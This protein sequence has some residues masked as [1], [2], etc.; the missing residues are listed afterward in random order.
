M[1][2]GSEGGELVSING[3]VLE[4]ELDLLRYLAKDMQKE[5]VSHVTIAMNVQGRR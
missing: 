1:V 2:G 3:V 5:L 4:E